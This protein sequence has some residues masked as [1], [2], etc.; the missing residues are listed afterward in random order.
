MTAPLSR[1]DI[2]QRCIEAAR[3][4]YEST[5]LEI[6]DN[7]PA[8]RGRDDGYWVQARVWVY[9]DQLEPLP[10]P[11]YSVWTADAVLDRASNTI[12]WPWIWV[13]DF[14]LDDDADGIHAR[15]AA[16]EHARYLRDTYICSYV[17]VRPT[18]SVPLPIHSDTN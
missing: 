6:L 9:D 10:G 2:S 3:R 7:A 11:T 13:A 8:T 12:H 16:H 4:I 18:G 1:G 15:A 14:T 17:A 5:D